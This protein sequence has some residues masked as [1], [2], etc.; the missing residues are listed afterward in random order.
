[1]TIPSRLTFALG[2]ALLLL[3]HHTV[4]PLLGWRIEVDW[5]VIALVLVALRSRPG[6]A[7]L[8]GFVLG[9][10]MDAM[11]PAA[12]GAAALVLT[13]VGYAAARFRAGFFGASVL[14]GT[15]IIGLGKFLSDVAV[16]VA[17]G[18]LRGVGFAAQ[19]GLWSPLSAALTAMVGAG[20]LGLARTEAPGPRRR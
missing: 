3:L 6:I 8:V 10:V 14:L 17:E 11:V 9:I 20:L 7:A 13:L 18:R 19:V 5:Q 2:I 4:R 12:L 16:V 1:M 15:V